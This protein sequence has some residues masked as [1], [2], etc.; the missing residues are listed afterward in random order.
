MA[1]TPQGAIV[2]GDVLPPE[3]RGLSMPA[4]T[5]FGMGI[6]GGPK[7]SGLRRPLRSWVERGMVGECEPQRLQE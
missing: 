6:F 2:R 1:D 7:F 5:P 4:G 3:N